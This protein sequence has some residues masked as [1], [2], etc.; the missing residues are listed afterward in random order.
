MVGQFGPLDISSALLQGTT[1]VDSAM[2]NV[3]AHVGVC[4]GDGCGHGRCHGEKQ[5]AGS[6]RAGH[7]ELAAG[8]GEGG[9]FGCTATRAAPALPG[10]STAGS[11]ARPCHA[12][13]PR[14]LRS[15]RLDCIPLPLW[16]IWSPGRTF[17][18]VGGVTP[19]GRC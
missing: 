17:L 4:Q 13:C 19:A 7:R 3:G 16:D 14:T 11:R 12:S 15:S 10:R 18:R 1:V 2:S 8:A 9:V 6:S 5:R